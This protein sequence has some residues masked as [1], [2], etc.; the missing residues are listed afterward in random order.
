[1]AGCDYLPS[2]PRLGLKT[3]INHYSKHRN[4]ENVISYLKKKD[5]YMD[6]MPKNYDKAVQKC[7]QLFQYQT[8]YCPLKKK[9]RPIN[10]IP[11]AISQ[12]LD[13]DFFGE[14]IDKE[15]IDTFVYGQ[16]DKKTMEARV[17]YIFDIKPVARDMQQ[18]RQLSSQ[19]FLYISKLF[20]FTTPAYDR[21][22]IVRIVEKVGQKKD[23]WQE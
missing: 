1:M 21:M 12:T 16:V 3:S 20:Y 8:I 7:K 15:K 17:P 2:V 22:K 6:K 5:T 19:T 10:T 14:Y 11:K 4:F 23:G 13:L 18:D 9:Q